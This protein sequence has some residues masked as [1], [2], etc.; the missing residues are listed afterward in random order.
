MEEKKKP[1]EYGMVG[2]DGLTMEERLQKY[3]GVTDWGYLR[4]AC[5]YE[6]LY[7]VDQE[8][9]LNVVA[10][11]FLEDDSSVIAEWLKKGDL[12][13]LE[14]LHLQHFD[15]DKAK[16]FEATVVSPFVLCKEYLKP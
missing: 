5:M 9:E 6:V 12:V 15:K 8:L 1:M 10:N 16:E 2:E 7:Y 4:A 13:K 14:T 3:S 11:A